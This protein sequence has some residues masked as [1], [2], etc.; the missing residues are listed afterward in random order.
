MWNK[1]WILY[2]CLSS[3][4]GLSGILLLLENLKNSILPFLVIY[5]SIYLLYAGLTF[6][7]LKRKKISI[8]PFIIT[9]LVICFFYY[10]IR[11]EI[12]HDVFS[13]L[14][15]GELIS[16]GINPYLV[17]PAD[18][19]LVEFQN[20]ELFTLN[21]WR[22]STT[23]YPPM[24]LTIFSLVYRMYENFG[25]GGAKIILSLPFFALAWL[26]YKFF[27]K[28]IFALFILNPLILFETFANG[29]VDIWTAFFVFVS[30]KL[31]FSNRINFSSIFLTLSVLMKLI[32]AVIFP[33]ILYNIF[34]KN[35]KKLYVRRKNA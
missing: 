26:F 29:H 2:T 32:P 8:L 12:S 27:D 13:Y 21:V 30:L 9:S 35:K 34:R 19:Q 3:L 7:L 4:A 15:D 22:D 23:I 1:N 28:K 11:P 24:S 25:I 17:A 18:P 6:I 31:F 14:M 20:S 10:Q 16:R 5:S 33:Y